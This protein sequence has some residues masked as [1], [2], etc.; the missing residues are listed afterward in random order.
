M[1]SVPS[2]YLH[3]RLVVNKRTSVLSV[4]R[5]LCSIPDRVLRNRTLPRGSLVY[6]YTFL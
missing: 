5:S 6:S 2:F 1:V 3:L 4:T